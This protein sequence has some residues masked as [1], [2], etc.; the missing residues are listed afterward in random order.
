MLRRVCL[1]AVS[2]L[3][4]IEH[5]TVSFGVVHSA[6]SRS[7]TSQGFLLNTELRAHSF[8]TLFEYPHRRSAYATQCRLTQRDDDLAHHGV[9]VD[10]LPID[11]YT[12]C[13]L[14]LQNPSLQH[15]HTAAIPSHLACIPPIH[16]QRLFEKRDYINSIAPLKQAV[17]VEPQLTPRRAIHFHFNA[18]IT[19][20]EVM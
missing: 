8:L 14:V 6:R 19:Q 2:L 20:C 16:A 13:R 10:D 5:I 17:C 1:R 9:L 3:S 18:L 7:G 15:S 12:L 4:R 11:A